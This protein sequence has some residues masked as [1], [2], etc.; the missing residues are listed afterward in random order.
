EEVAR[1]PVIAAGTGEVLD[2]LAEVAP[3]QFG[4]ALARRTDQHHSETFIEGHRDQR[5]LAIARDAFNAYALRI[6][7]THCFQIVEGTT[8]TP[9]PR[10]QCAPVFGLARRALVG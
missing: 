4:A 10:A 1:H 2:G 3:M 7:F 5:G 6:D 9:T 8:G